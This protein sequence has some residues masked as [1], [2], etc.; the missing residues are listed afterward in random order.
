MFYAPRLLLPLQTLPRTRGRERTW[1][2]VAGNEAWRDAMKKSSTTR[3][4]PSPR[5][6]GELRIS[7]RGPGRTGA[8][9]ARPRGN[10]QA[11]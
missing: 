2:V 1:Q 3:R 7:A 11:M 8:A 6:T 5:S 4:P 9:E 10:L